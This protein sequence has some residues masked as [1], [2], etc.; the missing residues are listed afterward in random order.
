MRSSLPEQ[1]PQIALL[2]CVMLAVG[3]VCVLLERAENAERLGVAKS[4]WDRHREVVRKNMT[5]VWY[6]RAW[7]KVL[8]VARLGES[9]RRKA[10]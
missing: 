1:A 2:L 6:E 7:R 3:A 8:G 5:E 10:A 9:K 4:E